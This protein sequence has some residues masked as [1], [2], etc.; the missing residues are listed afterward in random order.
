ML[1]RAALLL[2]LAWTSG[3]HCQDCPEAW[4]RFRDSCY[5]MGEDYP[6]GSYYETAA[7]C[8]GL[9]QT[10]DGREA[11][12]LAEINSMDEFEFLEAAVK[13]TSYNTGPWIG[14]IRSNHS[15][16]KFMLPT[17][18]TETGDAMFDEYMELLGLGNI[19]MGDN[20][21]GF[22]RHGNGFGYWNCSLAGTPLCEM[23]L[24]SVPPPLNGTVRTPAATVA[25]SVYTMAK[26]TAALREGC[27]Q[28]PGWTRLGKNCYFLANDFMS[29]NYF[30]ATAFCQGFGR[31]A[32]L[33]EVKSANE[34][35]AIVD[36]MLSASSTT[37][38]VW[39]S[40]LRTPR[41]SKKPI[42][43]ASLRS[44]DATAD[45]LFQ[46]SV[47]EAGEWALD[48]AR[49]GQLAREYGDAYGAFL[50]TF[51]DCKDSVALPL[52]EIGLE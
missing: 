33:A 46:Q 23:K 19:R 39:L 26:Q 51:G 15:S 6:G 1:Q 11:A 25:S 43:P 32:H 30:Q 35:D 52:C 31:N 40:L 38:R 50:V 4:R 5:F 29:V 9:G 47:R 3:V 21:V 45:P 34:R 13:N 7:F 27:P 28:L 24:A 8:R 20:C 22:D 14:L 48:G 49:C 44:L 18:L 36:N 2:V 41:F 10:V 17:T 37:D 16:D 12:Y 42:L